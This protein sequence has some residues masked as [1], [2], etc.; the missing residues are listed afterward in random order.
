L[1]LLRRSDGPRW[2]VL[3]HPKSKSYLL[4]QLERDSAQDGLNANRVQER[5]ESIHKS[6]LEWSAVDGR[7]A[8]QLE[9]HYQLFL[10][11]YTPTDSINATLDEVW[12]RLVSLEESRGKQTLPLASPTG[13]QGRKPGTSD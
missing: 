3:L 9:T 7:H 11:R 12:Q 1:Y 13:V 2:E 8:A 6:A 4:A 5:R 10:R